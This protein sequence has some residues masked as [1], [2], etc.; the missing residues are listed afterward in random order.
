MISNFA[1]VLFSSHSY[2]SYTYCSIKITLYFPLRCTKRLK[3]MHQKQIIPR[4]LLIVI[5]NVCVID[6]KLFN[7][8]N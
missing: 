3:T 6:T 2:T 5:Q 4:C 8:K 7:D 1:S